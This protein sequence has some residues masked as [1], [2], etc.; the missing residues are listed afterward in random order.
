MT[1]DK[2]KKLTDILV[3]RFA[4]NNKEPYRYFK[5]SITNNSFKIRRTY[6][7]RSFSPIIEGSITKVNSGSLIHV[8]AYI[9]TIEEISLICGTAGALV[10]WI[11]ERAYLIIFG[12]CIFFT[13]YIYDYLIN[14]RADRKKLKEILQANEIAMTTDL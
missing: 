12:V 5:G 4:F 7:D 3:E 8:V 9:P 1:I 6:A 10:Y 13:Y 14:R 2:Q 11:Q